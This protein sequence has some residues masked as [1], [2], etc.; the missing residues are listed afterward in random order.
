MTWLGYQLAETNLISP[1]VYLIEI[2]LA[3]GPMFGGMGHTRN[4]HMFDLDQMQ[5]E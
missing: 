3:L 4:R 2:L 1:F 5:L